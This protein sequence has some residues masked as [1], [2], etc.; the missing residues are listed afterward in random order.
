MQTHHNHHNFSKIVNKITGQPES[1]ALK[2]NYTFGKTLGAGSFGVVRHARNNS[3]GEEVAI[4]IMLKN[5]LKGHEQVVYDEIN[6]LKNLNH[7]NIVGFRDWFE[8]K[9]KIYIVTQLAIG[10]ELFERI[11]EKGSFTENDAGEVI[12]QIL[13]ALGYLHD[14]DIVHRDVKPENVLYLDKSDSSPIV[15]ADFGIAKK[16][17][18]PDQLLT[19]MAGSFGYVAPEVLKGTG[20]GKPC[21]IWSLGVITYT[22]LCGYLPFR[23][24]NV[25]DFLEEVNYN[26]PVIFH[27]RYWSNISKDA[28]FF[29]LKALAPNPSDRPT[30]RELLTDSWLIETCKL[31][32]EFDL[33]PNVKE[34]FDARKKFREVIELVR[35]NNRIKRLKSLASETDDDVSELDYHLSSASSSSV[36]SLSANLPGERGKSLLDALERTHLSN[37]SASSISSESN[38]SANTKSK[39]NP[40]LDALHQVIMTAKHNKERVQSYKE[41]ENT[42]D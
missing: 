25:H 28:R 13:L 35:L 4:K 3:T 8:S 19:S 42:D 16:L 7:P 20:H 15:L 18:T 39:S 32:K 29:I 23:A 40:H 37:P 27:E 26:N 12:Y 30:V 11:V 1:Y 31:H 5:A 34:G 33:L 2:Q 10:G 41:K 14:Q 24:E 6:M 9:D 17:S 38:N 21:D 36:S 22:L